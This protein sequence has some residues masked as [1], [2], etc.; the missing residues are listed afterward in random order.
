MILSRKW[1]SPLLVLS[2][3]SSILQVECI[4]SI[5]ACIGS[6]PSQMPCFHGQTGIRDWV[7]QVWQHAAIMDQWKSHEMVCSGV[8]CSGVDSHLELWMWCTSLGCKDQILITWDVNVFQDDPISTL[9]VSTVAPHSSSLYRILFSLH[10]SHSN[11]NTDARW[12]NKKLRQLVTRSSGHMW[13]AKAQN[14]LHG[15]VYQ[16]SN[17]C[18]LT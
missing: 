11:L 6:L 17:S 1:V 14:W 18:V 5:R 8:D 13:S 4:S 3:F 9:K 7:G 16:F 15:I 2:A 10:F 12:H